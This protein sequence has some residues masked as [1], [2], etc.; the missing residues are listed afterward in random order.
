MKHRVTLI[1]VIAFVFT[2][3]AAIILYRLFPS[4]QADLIPDPQL[5]EF[6]V[7][8]L[9]RLRIFAAPT[10]VILA[11]LLLCHLWIQR[12][13]ADERRALQKRDDDFARWLEHEIRGPLH[14]IQ[15]ILPELSRDTHQ[16]NL[17]VL[18]EKQ[19]D[20]LD[21]ILRRTGLLLKV[22]KD[23]KE[24]LTGE[25]AELGILLQDVVESQRGLH[26]K[27]QIDWG[28]DPLTVSLGRVKCDR[29]LLSQAFTNLIDN[30][31]K[32][33]END[34][35][36]HAQG[37]GKIAKV[38]ISDSGMGIPEEDQPRIS[39][40][41]FRARNARDK[42]ELP[43]IGMGLWIVKHTIE[44][45]SGHFE[46]ISRPNKGTRFEVSLPVVRE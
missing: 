21:E 25:Y 22:V 39:E 23:G 30:A 28:I 14:N 10:A 2:L 5:D 43:G 17:L 31:L 12:Q 13:I 4:V 15:N 20:R 44:I 16:Q 24:S 7:W 19:A 32:Y 45:H 8:A 46:V 34:V 37:N 18:L 42:A 3:V 9:L 11:F 26:P 38:Q 6:T 1:L 36:V 35:H 33:S 41:F 29:V 27:R 40:R